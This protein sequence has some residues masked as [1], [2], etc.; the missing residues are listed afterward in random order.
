MDLYLMVDGG[1]AN[2]AK[3]AA[4]NQPRDEALRWFDE[5][6][7]PLRRYLMCAGESPADADD[8]VQE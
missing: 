7:D 6:R 8:A 1:K 2:V 5:L 4:V 3:A